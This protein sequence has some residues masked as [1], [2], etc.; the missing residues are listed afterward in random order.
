VTLD[1][2]AVTMETTTATEA[3]GAGLSAE[4]AAIFG[5]GVVGAHLEGELQIIARQVEAAHRDRRDTVALRIAAAG[6]TPEP[7]AAAYAMPFPVTDAATAMKL[8]VALEEGAA[9]AWRN[10][11]GTTTGEDR[12]IALDALMAAAVQATRWRVAA[13]ITPV[14]VPLPGSSPS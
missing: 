10:A 12:K 6:G 9:G 7:A 11:L 4:H 3:L 14:T 5:Y 1:Q 13:G 8:A 2:A